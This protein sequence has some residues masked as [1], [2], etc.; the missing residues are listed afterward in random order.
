MIRSASTSGRLFSG[1][2]SFSDRLC[3][4]RFQ[5]LLDDYRQL[6]EE[7]DGWFAACVE[8]VGDEIRC[9]KGCSACCRGLFDIS[10]LDAALLKAGFLQLEPEVRE[11]VLA[12]ARERVHALQAQWP[13][14][15]PPYLLNRLPHEEWLDMP[16]DDP[17]P[18]PL[19]G[20]EGQCL[21]YAHR[22][23]ICRTHGLP[24]IDSSGEIF[25]DAVC[26][27]NFKTRD[28]LTVPGLRHPFRATFEREFALLERFAE[29][30]LGQRRCEFDTFI[31]CAVL[32]D[33]SAQGWTSLPHEEKE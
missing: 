17:I 10:L 20:D 25:S 6:L 4:E 1:R 3:V 29:R 24:N 15:E 7:L 5:D 21:V 30:L 2:T 22:P 11:R 16:E 26:T 14:F 27:L 32:I 12:R 8:Q 18:C 19:L 31:P 23:M 9:C 13:E 33:F 28:P